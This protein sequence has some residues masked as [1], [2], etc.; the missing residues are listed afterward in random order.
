MHSHTLGY[1]Q[2]DTD[3]YSLN[4]VKINLQLSF[5]LSMTLMKV[6]LTSYVGFMSLIR[7]ITR[8]VVNSNFGKLQQQFRQKILP[9]L[10]HCFIWRGWYLM[11]ENL[12]LIWVEFS[13]LS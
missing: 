11:G 3:I 13:T 2:I 6:N 5:S 7:S 1:R 8:N 4:V 12:E 9:S 10:S